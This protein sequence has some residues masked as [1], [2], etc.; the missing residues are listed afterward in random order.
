VD[1]SE[2]QKE[3]IAATCEKD[4]NGIVP[5]RISLFPER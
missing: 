1:K 3:K 5:K 4:F 2:V